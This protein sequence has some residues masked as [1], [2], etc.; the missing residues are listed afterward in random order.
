MAQMRAAGR[1]RRR[2]ACRR[3]NGPGWPT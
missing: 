3:R 1:G 2:P